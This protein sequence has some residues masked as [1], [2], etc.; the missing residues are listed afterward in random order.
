M[1]CLKNEQ[2]AYE[3]ISR[4]TPGVG[5]L[6]KTPEGTGTVTAVSPL[7]GILT[8]SLEHGDERELKEYKVDEVKILKRATV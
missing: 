1:C 2:E 4:N 8:V 6:I 7:K 5:S 3:E